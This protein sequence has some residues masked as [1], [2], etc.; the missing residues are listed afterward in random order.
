MVKRKGVTV[1]NPVSELV[2][3]TV[4]AYVRDWTTNLENGRM[5]R[6][7]ELHQLKVM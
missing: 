6:G 4:L 1:P 3:H 5:L 7:K 2:I